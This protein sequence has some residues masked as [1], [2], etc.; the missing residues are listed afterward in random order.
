MTQS[1]YSAIWRL[2]G[3][4]L[5]FI[6]INH[7]VSQSVTHS[8][9]RVGIELLRQLT[10]DTIDKNIA[11]LSFVSSKALLKGSIRWLS[12]H[13]TSH[14]ICCHRLARSTTRKNCSGAPWSRHC[15]LLRKL[16][17]FGPPMTYEKNISLFSFIYEFKVDHSWSCLWVC[18]PNGWWCINK[19]VEDPHLAV[20]ATK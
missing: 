16:R 1:E 14:T 18:R 11:F 3:R 7:S 19:E 9:T 5:K 10:I 17:F 2:I 8:L 20:L 6:I 13:L 4:S 12:I 15:P